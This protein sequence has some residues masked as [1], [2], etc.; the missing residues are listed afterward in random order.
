MVWE[1]AIAPD[2]SCF[3]SV[4]WGM[5]QDRDL[6]FK[7]CLDRPG[8]TES[9]AESP[10]PPRP[11]QGLCLVQSEEHCSLHLTWDQR[12]VVE[13]CSAQQTSCCLEIWH[14]HCHSTIKTNASHFTSWV[15]DQKVKVK[16]FRRA[17]HMY[18]LDLPFLEMVARVQS[19]ILTQ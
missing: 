10:S 2:G 19:L 13:C 7:R 17:I 15:K 16:P 8:S 14:W 5:A 1:R 6:L 3:W 4:S 11:R 9:H 18:G 12:I